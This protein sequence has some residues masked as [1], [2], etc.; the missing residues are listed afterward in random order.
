[1]IRIPHQ[2]QHAVAN[3]IRRRLLAADHRHDA[4]GDYLFIGQAIAVDL[5]GDERID[6]SVAR[7]R[8]L[9][10]QRVAKIFGH[11]GNAFQSSRRSIRV[12]L[13]V[14]EHFGEICRPGLQLIGI[15]RR[16]PE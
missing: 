8:P 6:Q 2:R 5:G 1:M 13:K 7:V 11:L 16:H 12:V 9:L 14:S 3:Q 10:L 15:G 4:V